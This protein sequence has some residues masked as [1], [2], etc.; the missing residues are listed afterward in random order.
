[1]QQVGIPSGRGHWACH[2]PQGFLLRRLS[3]IAKTLSLADPTYVLQL[4]LRI[5]GVSQKLCDQ[6]LLQQSLP[7]RGPK[8]HPRVRAFPR[9]KGTSFT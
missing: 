1:M 5:A 7:R 8:V 3:E 6:V 4:S 9:R 2:S